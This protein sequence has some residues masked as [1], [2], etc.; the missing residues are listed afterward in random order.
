MS[1]SKAFYLTAE[2]NSFSGYSVTFELHSRT[3]I[4][5]AL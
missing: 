5:Y 2:V 4:S 3:N 1:V